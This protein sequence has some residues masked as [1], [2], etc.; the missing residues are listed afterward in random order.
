MKKK[1]ITKLVLKITEGLVARV[2]D[3]ALLWVFIGYELVPT[4]SRSPGY[5]LDKAYQDLLE[6]NYETIKRGLKYAQQKGWITEDLKITKKGRERL[7]SILPQYQK[8]KKWDGNWYLVSYDIPENKKKL[9]E[10][11][12]ATLK[13]LGFGQVHQSLWISAYNFLGEVEQVI[14]DYNLSNYVILG[15][16]DRIGTEPSKILA[17]KIWKLNKINEEYK[18][19]IEKIKSQKL[20][21]TQISFFY[22]SILKKDSQLPKELLPENWYGDQAFEIYNSCFKN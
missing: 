21:K 17:E 19:F 13:K 20:S 4:K 9:R 8:A 2:V 15:I 12:R 14:K 10:I 16:S 11:L 22:F 3:L 7:E 18:K 5:K 6:I 1:E